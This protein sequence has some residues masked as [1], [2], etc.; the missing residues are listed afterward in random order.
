ML[1]GEDTARNPL[2][3]TTTTTLNSPSQSDLQAGLDQYQF[4]NLLDVSNIRDQVRLRTLAEKNHTSAWLK[5]IPW[6]FLCLAPSSLWQLRS[7]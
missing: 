4:E 6:D 3:D 5:A 2:I 7:G 1:P